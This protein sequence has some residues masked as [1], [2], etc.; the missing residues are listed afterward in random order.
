[1][2]SGDEV[3]SLALI[4]GDMWYMVFIAIKFAKLVF[5]IF[6]LQFYFLMNEVQFSQ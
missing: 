2:G 4:A 5:D 1:M 3:L 6:T